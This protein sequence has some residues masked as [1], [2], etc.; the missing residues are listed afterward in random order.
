MK[1]LKADGGNVYGRNI[2]NKYSDCSSGWMVDFFNRLLSRADFMV[3]L[4]AGYD[5]AIGRN[6]LPHR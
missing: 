4:S 5:K 3:W 6:A 1:R 2:Y